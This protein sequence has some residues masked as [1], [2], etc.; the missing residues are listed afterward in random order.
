MGRSSADSG[1]HPPDRAA[2]LDCL[3]TFTFGDAA[4]YL[5]DELAKRGP[6]GTSTKPVLTTFPARAKTAVPL[7]LSVPI[8]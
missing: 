2:N 1:R 6:I 8:C 4:P 7:L 3:E 5:K